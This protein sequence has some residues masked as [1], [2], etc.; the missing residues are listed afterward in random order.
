MTDVIWDIMREHL[1][2]AEFLV[3]MWSNGVDS[4][5]FDFAKLR[6]GPE[7]RLLAHLDALRVGGEIVVER[8]LLPVMADPD[9]DEFRTAAASLAILHGAGLEACERVLSAFDRATG[10]GHR[11]LV[12]GLSL[13]SREGLIPWLGRD[14]DQLAPG[15]LA[16]RL[17]I[18]A[19][20]RV[21]VGQRLIG[22]LGATDLDVRRAAAVLARHTGAPP[23]LHMLHGLFDHEDDALRWAAIE[24]GL[25]RGQTPAWLALAREAFG[26]RNSVNHR[27]A[28]GWLAMLGD[29]SIHQRLLAALQAGP[30]PALVWAAGLTG[31]PQAVDLGIE[32]L[33]DPC[34][35]RLAGELVCAVA[36]L[37]DDDGDHWLDRGVR[38]GDDPDDALPQLEHDDLEIPSGDTKLRLPN[39]DAL[40]SWWAHRRGQ[41]DPR[42]RYSN[43]APLDLPA[44]AR[45][46]AALPTR[47]RHP[48]ALELAARTTGRAQIATWAMTGAQHLQAQDVFSR[49]AFA[50][51]QRGLPSQR[52]R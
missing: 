23:A 29:A 9:D 38:I 24:S 36:G 42:L 15:V 13:S 48:L 1:D 43:G 39:P 10:I 32:L 25:I 47:R 7:A 22:W 8:V 40:R 33:D 35:A 20:H 17:R 14:L 49:L 12:R 34:L 31:R 46:F 5:K 26:G 30:T 6:A 16:S 50:D 37:R 44:L 11:G 45:S 51:F 28:F 52:P 19:A 4:P 18:L 27:E 2:E 21:N 41:F 3:E